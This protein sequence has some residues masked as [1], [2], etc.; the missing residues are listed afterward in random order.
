MKRNRRAGVEDL[1]TKTVRDEHGN[2]QAVPSAR[3]GIG[4]R[5]RAAICRR[6]RP[7]STRKRLP[8]RSMRRSGSD[9]QTAA[10]VSG[11]HVAPRDA[12]LTVAAVVRSVDAGLSDTPRIHGAVGQYSHSADRRPSSAVCRCRRC[13]RHRSRHGWLGYRPRAWKRPTSIGCTPGCR[14][15]CADAVH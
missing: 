4:L 13:G 15:S 8:A 3:H 2:T 14:K 10:V 7:V 5:W 12:Q 9:G 1:W 11:T 6:A